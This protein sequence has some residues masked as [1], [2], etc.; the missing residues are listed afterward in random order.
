[1]RVPLQL[2]GRSSGQLSCGSSFF[3]RSLSSLLRDPLGGHQEEHSAPVVLTCQASE[4]CKEQMVTEEG[5]LSPKVCW[6][7]WPVYPPPSRLPPG[8]VTLPCTCLL[9]E[10][11]LVVNIPPDQSSSLAREAREGKKHGCGVWGQSKLTIGLL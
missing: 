3:N 7:P 5:N 4:N 2:P 9:P 11:S 6:C 8:A 1:M 10:S